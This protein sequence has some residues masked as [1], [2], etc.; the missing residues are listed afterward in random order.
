M[1]Q[2]LIDTDVLINF[3]RGNVVA[4]DF[5]TSMINEAD[6]SC[7]AITIAEIHAGMK[8]HER[9]KTMELLSGLTIVDVTLKI[10]E[11]AGSYKRNTKS[12][13]LELDD[14]LIAATAFVRR[15]ILATGNGK[16]YPMKD[17]EK[18]IVSLKM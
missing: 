7:S 10:A 8:E 16:H 2:V 5:L 13:S 1:M 6:L 11:K 15:A 14:C 9:D 12:Q 3:L 17:I 18:K 4:R